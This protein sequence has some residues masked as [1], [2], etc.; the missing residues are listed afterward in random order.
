MDHARSLT[1]TATTLTAAL[2]A[3]NLLLSNLTTAIGQPELLFCS[4]V[5]LSGFY[6]GGGPSYHFTISVGVKYQG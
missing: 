3:A 2:A 4:N 6:D 5:T 1:A